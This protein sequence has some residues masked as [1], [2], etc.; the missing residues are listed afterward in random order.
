MINRNFI[1]NKENLSDENYIEI[2]LKIF[3]VFTFY[4]EG[5]LVCVVF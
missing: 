3:K 2:I 5:V 4:S 1:E